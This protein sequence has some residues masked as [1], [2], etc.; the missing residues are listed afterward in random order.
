MR[1]MAFGR[2]PAQARLL[3][4]PPEGRR[5]LHESL[6]SLAINRTRARNVLVIYGDLLPGRN[7]C[8]GNDLSSATPKV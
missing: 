3:L 8:Q 1:R 4:I 6:I 5:L 2:T 7:V